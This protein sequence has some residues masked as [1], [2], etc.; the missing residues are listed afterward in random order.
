[1]IPCGWLTYR[2]IQRTI[3]LLDQNV[4]QQLVTMTFIQILLVIVSFL[5]YGIYML[6]IFITTDW[7]LNANQLYIDDTFSTSVN[8]IVNLFNNVCF[9]VN[10][11]NNV[12]ISLSKSIQSKFA[13]EQLVSI[14]FSYRIQS[15]PNQLDKKLLRN[16]LHDHVQILLM[17]CLANEDQV[18]TMKYSNEDHH[19]V[20]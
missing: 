17:D 5:P 4:D 7:I 13:F 16:D 19:I 15:N 18:S 8:L 12:G 3:V 6:Y 9:F 20:L 1:M 11:F 2:N 14:L 10:S